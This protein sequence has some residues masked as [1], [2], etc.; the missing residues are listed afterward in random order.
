MDEQRDLLKAATLRD[1]EAFSFSGL[2]GP[3]KVVK[4]TD[5]DTVHIVTF[6][7]CELIRLVCRL[8]GINA[9]ELRLEHERAMASKRR[10]FELCC[11]VPYDNGDIDKN[12]RIL[13][14]ECLGEEKYGRQLVRLYDK[15]SDPDNVRDINKMMLD[16][17][18]AVAYMV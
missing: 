8:S 5:G 13:H 2:S 4:V 9:P 17:G 1:I 18:F 6:Y 7:K 14:V 11:N 15:E 10:L 16:E 3:C 12:T